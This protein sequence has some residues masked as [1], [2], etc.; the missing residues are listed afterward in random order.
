MGDVSNPV[1]SIERNTTRQRGMMACGGTDMEI[2]YLLSVL[3]GHDRIMILE[4]DALPCF[5][6]LQRAVFQQDTIQ[7][8]MAISRKQNL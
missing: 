6:W 4:S 7:P 8:H 5:Q 1:P 3:E 2:R